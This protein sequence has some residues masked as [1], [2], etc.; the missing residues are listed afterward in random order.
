MI[1][2]RNRDNERS[3][4]QFGAVPVVGTIPWLDTINRET[5]LS[6][7]RSNFDQK[8]FRDAH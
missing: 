6:V 4:E 1:G 2:H 5:L 8:Y 7:F 3:V